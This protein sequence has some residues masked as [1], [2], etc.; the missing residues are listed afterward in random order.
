MKH[1]KVNVFFAEV[2]YV[3]MTFCGVERARIHRPFVGIHIVTLPIHMYMDCTSIM[4]ICSTFVHL[5]E[6]YLFQQFVIE[7]SIFTIISSDCCV[8]TNSNFSSKLL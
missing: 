3:A 5:N 8:V 2:T 4:C 1:R 7:D 6:F